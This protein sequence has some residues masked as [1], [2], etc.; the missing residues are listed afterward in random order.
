MLLI[1][2]FFR[3][4]MTGLSPTVRPV[5]KNKDDHPRYMPLYRLHQLALKYLRSEDI[6]HDEATR[7]PLTRAEIGTNLASFFVRDDDIR[8]SHPSVTGFYYVKV[9]PPNARA[10]VG[11][12]A[13]EGVGIKI[14]INTAAMRGC[15]IVISFT[16][17]AWLKIRGKWRPLQLAV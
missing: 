9:V 7:V 3:T 15:T 1:T 2:R 5:F 12:P 11:T 4:D 14:E 6:F 13:H 8:S 17:G 10:R 16:P